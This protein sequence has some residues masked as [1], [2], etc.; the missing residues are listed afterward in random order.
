[1]KWYEWTRHVRDECDAPPDVKALLVTM[2]TYADDEGRCWPSL[3]KLAANLNVHPDTA[4]RRRNRAV[5][6]GWLV[7]EAP[8]R[9]HGT[10][11]RYRIR[12]G[13]TY[14]PLRTEERGASMGRKGVHSAPSKGCTG[15]P[16][17][18]TTFHEG[19]NGAPSME[20]RLSPI[21]QRRAL[22][23]QIREA[24]DPTFKERFETRFH[25]DYGHLYPPRS[26]AA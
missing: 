21:D 16:R 17:T 6:L 22:A 10:P 24:S 11:T 18:S 7:I 4:K 14:A 3:A 9:W 5:Q 23:R 20:A 15:A 8:G 26:A 1:M 12:K 25:R 19:D 2:S 13:G